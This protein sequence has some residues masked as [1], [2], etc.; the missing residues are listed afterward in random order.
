LRELHN[1]AKIRVPSLFIGV[2]M[3]VLATAGLG[4]ISPID[5]EVHAQTSSC[6]EVVVS[7]LDCSPSTSP[8]SSDDSAD[9]DDNDE[10]VDD[11]GNI[12][13]NDNSEDQKDD[14]KGGDI[15]S[16]IP[17]VAGGGVPFP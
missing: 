1:N 11:R 9:A 15:E 14:K 6:D 16:K 4:N 8:P 7:L 13:K 17:S 10:N 2:M 12:D 5:F 3:L